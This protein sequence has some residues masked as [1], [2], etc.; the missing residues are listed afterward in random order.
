MLCI[1]L[2]NRNSSIVHALFDPF[3]LLVVIFE[4]YTI[5]IVKLE[6]QYIKLGSHQASKAISVKEVQVALHRL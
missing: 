5:K 3:L 6:E 2:R 4:N 1:L